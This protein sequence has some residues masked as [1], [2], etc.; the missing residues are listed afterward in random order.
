MKSSALEAVMSYWPMQNVSKREAVG[1]RTLIS[2]IL[3]ILTHLAI[4]TDWAWASK[5]ST[6]VLREREEFSGDSRSSS[7]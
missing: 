4:L 5:S 6:R 1:I 7:I 3:I 2:Y